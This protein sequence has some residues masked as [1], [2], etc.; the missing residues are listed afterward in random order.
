[1]GKR[2]IQQARGKGSSTYRVSK[3]AFKYRLQYPPRMIGTAKVLKLVNSSA[4]SAPLAKVQFEKQIFFIPAF[5][6]MV[7]GQQIQLGGK[8]VQKGNIM[9][10]KDLPVKTR[11]YCIESR[12]GDGGRFI[13]TGG[14]FATVN[15]KMGQEVFI[16]MPSKKEK[17]MNG[18][19]RAIVGEIAGSGRVDKPVLKAGKKHHIKK[20]KSKLWPRTSALKVNAIDHPFGS[21]RG[22]NPK[23]KIAKRN[24]PPGA[25]V[26]LLRPRRTGKRK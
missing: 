11:I 4:H 22:K 17:K 18:N 26:G 10:L 8:E 12:P 21:G 7:E 5:N 3:K 13:K 9:A 15:R 1:M 25:K 14:S 20:A 19:C 23:S 24:S 6:G 2:I 16:L